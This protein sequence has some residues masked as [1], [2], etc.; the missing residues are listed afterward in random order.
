MGEGEWREAREGEKA[1]EAER[2]EVG[3]KDC[4]LRER[5]KRSSPSI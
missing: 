5:A 2:G 3:P 1:A 4:T